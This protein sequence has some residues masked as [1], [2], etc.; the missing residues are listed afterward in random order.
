MSEIQR[1]YMTVMFCDVVGSTQ[2]AEQLDPEDFHEI[3]GDYQRAC[4]RAIERLDGYPARF[5]GDGVVAYFGFPIAYEDYAQRGVHAGLGILTEMAALN[6]RL[7][8][9][10]GI[11]LQVR[12]GL[13]TGLTVAGKM[14]PDRHRDELDIVGETP[15]L[16]SRLQEVAPPDSIVISDET[17]R[18]IEGYFETEP[19]GEHTLKGLSRPIAVHRVVRA[20]GAIGRLEAAATRRLTPLVGRDRELLR[21]QEAW[22]QV[23]LGRGA[24]VHLRGEAGIGKSR[25]A[26]ELLERVSR[27][28]AEQTWQCSAHHQTTFLYPVARAV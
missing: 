21:L 7:R 20:T 1:R 25:L 28:A 11:E 12:I 2:L 27:I 16:A 14:G 9:E 24:I 18:L 10:R 17:R 26:R 6:G 19:L 13:H 15:H 22:Y 23:Q 4:S 3:L 8:P 5:I